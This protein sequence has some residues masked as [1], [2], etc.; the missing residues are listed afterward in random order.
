MQW[1]AH[2]L[3]GKVEKAER[4]EYG[5]APLKVEGRTE[6]SQLFAGVPQSLRIWNSHG[7]HVRT[8]PAGF[9]ST[10][11]T[12]NAIASLEDPERKIDAV[13]FHVYGNPSERGT[14]LLR[15]FLFRV[16]KARPNARGT[17]V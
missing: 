14:S 10:G 7:D 12:D 11:H 1:I 9:R 5:R 4:R 17:T 13:Q 3:G 16:F 6:K 8:L 2:T 15:D